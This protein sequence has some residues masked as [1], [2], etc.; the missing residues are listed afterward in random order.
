MVTSLLLRLFG[1]KSQQ[2]VQNEH[3]LM[4]TSNENVSRS[5]YRYV[6]KQLYSAKRYELKSVFY[7][8]VIVFYLL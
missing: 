5:I 2:Q 4:A 1:Y 3:L 7:L 8:P 6:C